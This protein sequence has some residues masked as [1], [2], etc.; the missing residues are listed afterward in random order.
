MPDAAIDKVE[1]SSLPDGFEEET[2]IQL[3][4]AAIALAF[5]VD[6]RELFPAMGAG[7]TRADAML[8]HIKQRGKGPGQILQVLEQQFN[9]K[10]LPRDMKLVFDLQDDAQD[11]QEAEI[12]KIRADRRMQD[13]AA[14][15]MNTRTSR[16][17][18][19][20]D[21][22]IT[23]RQFE[24]LELED[25]RTP[26]GA[27]VIALFYANSGDYEDWL[28]VGTDD[29]LDRESNDKEAILQ[30]IRDR[31]S[32][33]SAVLA[34]DLKDLSKIDKAMEALA[35]LVKLDEYYRSEREM[36][37]K[38]LFGG[39]VEEVEEQEDDPRVRTQDTLT[40]NDDEEVNSGN[41]SI[42]QHPDDKVE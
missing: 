37:L 30:I 19:L 41:S 17:Q 21:K 23:R 6:A 20:E 31:F 8:Q 26:D 13:I 5:G 10:Y 29:P 18:M 36:S 28:D 7:A 16:E 32:Q 34:S 4:M 42:R 38:E 24:R 15:T 12:S 11:R 39:Q 9:Y 35:A 27:P 3:G 22:E 33:V 1:L 40:P 25:G 2:S 14:K